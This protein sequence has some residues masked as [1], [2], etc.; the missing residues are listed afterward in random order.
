MIAFA[1]TAPGFEAI[2]VVNAQDVLG[3]V[4]L[5]DLQMIESTAGGSELSG[6][7]RLQY[8]DNG[9]NPPYAGL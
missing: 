5:G 1:N 9:I 8:I 6:G 3:D 4:W 7:T 2:Y